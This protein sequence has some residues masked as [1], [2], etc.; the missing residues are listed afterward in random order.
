M[1][2]WKKVLIDGDFT[3]GDG[4]DIQN[5]TTG[6]I[7][8]DLKANGGLDIESGEIAVN[9]SDTNI[10]GTLAVGDGGTGLTSIAQGSILVANTADTLTALDGGGAGQDGYVLTYDGTADTI[11]WAAGAAGSVEGLSDT[12]ITSANSGEILIYHATNGWVNADITDGD[13]ITFTEADGSIT[14]GITDGGIA[15]AKL[16]NDDVTIGTTAIAL[17]ASSATLAGME[18]IDFA[19][20]NA[21]IAASIGAN[22]LTIGGATSTVS[23]AGT[24]E[25]Q[26]DINQITTSEL[27][28]TDKVIRT[29]N[30]ASTET[31][32]NGAGLSVDTSGITGWDA[33]AALLLET[34]SPSRFS[35][36][37]MVKGDTGSGSDAWVAA[38]VQAADYNALDALDPGIGTLGMAGSALYIQTA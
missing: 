17:G 14:V 16:A 10:T 23:I 27:V 8:V 29:A 12:T 37:R 36:W 35:E 4:I 33:D 13:G 9:L 20:G 21:A 2:T 5:T 30:G 11:S 3:G 26:G 31:A 6:E 34:V 38:M 28:V 1:S 19:A 7:R 22:T 18:G 32:A 25:I 15:N 24:L